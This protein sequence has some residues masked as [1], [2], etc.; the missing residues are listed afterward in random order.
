MAEDIIVLEPGDERAQKIGKAISSQTANDILHL[1]SDEPRTA[2]ELTDTLHIPMSTIKYHLDNLLSA[3]LLEVRETRYSVKGREI[4]VYAVRNQLVIVAPKLANI[5]SI[6][7][8]Y[9]S[10]FG[11][12][13]LASLVMLAILPLFQASP[14]VAGPPAFS[15]DGNGGAGAMETLTAEKGAE[16]MLA[17]PRPVSAPTAAPV[18][19]FFVGGCLVILVLL[20]IDTYRWQ[21]SR[22]A[23]RGSEIPPEA[24]SPDEGVA[25]PGGKEE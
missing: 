8:K 6:L 4:K 25:A 24:S 1:I 12:V 16:P 23:M 21:K 3:G 20:L 7:L 11:V 14:D 22:S 5:R 10:L 19:A 17:A 15:Q 2:S 9:A 13:I 18:L